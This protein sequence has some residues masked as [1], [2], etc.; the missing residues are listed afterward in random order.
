MSLVAEVEQEASRDGAY[1]EHAIVGAYL[2]RLDPTGGW[3]SGQS[4]GE[5]MSG[6]ISRLAAAGQLAAYGLPPGSQESAM[7]P[8]YL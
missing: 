6:Q 7:M 2:H 8:N 1:S 3:S 5:F 4:D